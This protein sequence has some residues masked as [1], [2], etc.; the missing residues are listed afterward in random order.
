MGAEGVNMGTRFMVTQE[1]PGHRGLKEWLVKAS[2]RDTVL[3]MRSLR[4]TMRAIK[5]SAAEQIIEMENQGAGLEQLAPLISGEEGKKLFE[6]G[7][8]NQG[9][10]SAGQSLG[11]VRDIPTVKE[12]IE[13]IMKEAKE[14]VSQIGARGTFKPLRKLPA[15]SSQ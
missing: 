3:V 7:L 6:T 15:P 1:A 13:S 11:L 9:L 12:L 14:V 10:W 5:N 2:E 8:M 4:N